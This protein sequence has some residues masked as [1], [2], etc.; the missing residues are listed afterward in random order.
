MGGRV[1]SQMLTELDGIEELKGVLVLGATNRLD[2]LDPAVLRPGRFDEVVE[3]PLPE[4]PERR[5]IDWT[6]LKTQGAGRFAGVMLSA[7]AVSIEAAR[8]SASKVPPSG[9]YILRS[10]C[11][12]VDL[13]LPV[14]PMIAIFCPAFI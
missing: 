4:E 2:R 12:T 8:T 1:L 13:P 11:A 10:N 5:A 9:L 14:L 3:I 7:H 6:M